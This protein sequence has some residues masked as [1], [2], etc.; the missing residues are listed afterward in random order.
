MRRLEKRGAIPSLLIALLAIFS[1]TGERGSRG[2]IPCKIAIYTK[3]IYYCVSCY[4]LKWDTILA[5]DKIRIEL[6]P[7]LLFFQK[8]EKSKFLFSYFS[9]WHKF[10]SVFI[11]FTFFKK[12][13]NAHWRQ[14]RMFLPLWGLPTAENVPF[15]ILFTVP[16]KTT[17]RTSGTKNKIT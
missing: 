5:F 10:L 13:G 17:G 8:I 4:P 14:E 15:S 9:I 11:I 16:V 12:S 1:L 7:L 6:F 3:G 2:F